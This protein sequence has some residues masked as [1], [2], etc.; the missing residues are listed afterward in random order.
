MIKNWLLTGDTHRRVVERIVAG[1]D[2]SKYNREETALIILGDV[3]L[4]FYLNKT[5]KK[6]KEL[7]QKT[8]C[9]VYC[10][11]GNHEARPQN[12]LHMEI[13]WDK[14]VQ[15]PVY[16][17]DG[18]PNIRYF[19]DWGSYIING[20]KCLVIGGA[21]SIDKWYRLNGLN[22]NTD[23]WTGWFKDEQL[24]PLEMA[25]C[26]NYITTVNNKY[27]FVLTH[28][29]P[30]SYEPTDLFI[31][32]S[33]TPD[34]SMELFLDEIRKLI[35]FKVWAFGHYHAD[36]LEKP[37]VIQMYYAI[38]DMNDIYAY[39]YGDNPRVE[40]EYWVRKGPL[41]YEGQN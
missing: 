17:E 22:S 19:L 16:V 27:D 35:D 1:I 6:E 7:V 39:W 26:R 5:D 14:E 29:C 40:T 8:G 18:F 11:R 9:R 32:I 21:Y 37:G 15:G 23:K 34:K 38:E 2:V 33:S 41:Y 12:L 31:N 3:G 13:V 10:V 4:N 30:I 25:R 36:R 28:T 24:T 20:F